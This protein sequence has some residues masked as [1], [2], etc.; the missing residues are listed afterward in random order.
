MTI[1]RAV[2]LVGSAKPAGTSTSEALGDYLLRRLEDRGVGPTVL[3]V[4]GA[5]TARVER[6]LAAALADADLFVLAAPVYVD[7]LP[8][9]VTRAFESV[10]RSTSDRRTSCAFTAIVNCGFPEAEQCRTALDIAQ[11]FARRAG[12]VWAGGLALGEGGTIDGKPLAGV[13]G[14]ARHVRRALDLA[15]G[16]LAVGAPVPAA[17]IEQ[18]AQPMMPPRLYTAIGNFGWR[19]RAGRNRVLSTLDARPFAGEATESRR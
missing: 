11:A 9:L 7:S 18:M 2:L 14:L 4:S 1:Q 8:H 19:L 15:A 10:A 16:A 13:G 5:P 6:R 17:A 12:F 3:R